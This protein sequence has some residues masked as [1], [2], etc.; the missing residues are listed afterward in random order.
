LVPS[1]SSDLL[2]QDGLALELVADQAARAGP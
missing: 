2:A 1:I